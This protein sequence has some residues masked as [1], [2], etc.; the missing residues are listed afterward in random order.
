[1][2]RKKLYIPSLILYVFVI[3]SVSIFGAPPGD[4]QAADQTEVSKLQY[5]ASQHEIISILIE[6]G[7]WSQAVA[8]F[9]K[10][11]DLDLGV[12]SEG[13]LTEE[14][15]QITEQ[16]LEAKQFDFSHE[17]IDSTLERCKLPN[18][19]FTLLILKG[20]VFKQEGEIKAALDAFRDAQALQ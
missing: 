3:L 7:D 15:W 14:A 17:I 12:E 13:S 11:L 16:L 9:Y 4:L 8:E 1:M 5:A 10:I 2:N 19:R 20:K 6:E 18:N